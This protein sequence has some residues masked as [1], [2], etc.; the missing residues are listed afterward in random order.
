MTIGTVIVAA[1]M[2]TRMK[3]FKQLMKIGDLSMAERV[4]LNFQRAGIRNIVMVTG[5]QGKLV[6]KSLQHF[7]STGTDCFSNLQGEIG[8]SYSH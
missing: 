8:S 4:V 5:F 2:S 1:G 6:E 3:D 7:G